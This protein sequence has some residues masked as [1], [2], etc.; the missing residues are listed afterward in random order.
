MPTIISV[1][2]LGEVSSTLWVKIIRW[3]WPLAF[4]LCSCWN[5]NTRILPSQFFWWS[6]VLF[7]CLCFI[8]SLQSHRCTPALCCS[9]WGKNQAC[10]SSYLCVRERKSSCE[11]FHIQAWILTILRFAAGLFC[12]FVGV[13]FLCNLVDRVYLHCVVAAGKNT[14]DCMPSW[15]L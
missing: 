1:Y 8:L 10:M 5:S 15:S 14:Q 3:W 6:F 13:F 7:V 4:F 11:E 9:S 12:C 2:I